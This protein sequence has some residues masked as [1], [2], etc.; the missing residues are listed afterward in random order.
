MWLTVG[1]SLIVVV[2][3]SIVLLLFGP[4]IVQLWTHGA[5]QPGFALIAAMTAV[6]VVN[7]IWHPLSNLL[8]AVN[9]QASYSYVYAVASGVAVALAYPLCQAFGVV[10]AGLAIVLLDLFMFQ[11]VV[12]RIARGYLTQVVPARERLRPSP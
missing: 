12:R 11:H 4:R 10:G 9:R 8:L 3:G 5:I 7:G 2:P 6:M 1:G